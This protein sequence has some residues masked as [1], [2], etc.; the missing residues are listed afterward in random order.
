MTVVYQEIKYTAI[1]STEAY[2]GTDIEGDSR[3]V[4]GDFNPDLRFPVFVNIDGSNRL[5]TAIGAYAFRNNERI[6]AVHIHRYIKEIR[7]YGFDRCYNLH[8]V[9]FDVDSN[10]ESI[11]VS[12]FYGCSFSSII[13]PK[14]L[15]KFGQDVLGYNKNLKTIFYLGM[16]NPSSSL[17]IFFNGTNPATIYVGYDYPYDKFYN[18]VVTKIY[19]IPKKQSVMCN[20]KVGSLVNFLFVIYLS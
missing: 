6:K 10:L 19:G 15:K 1:N 5:I 2:V 14:T 8:K 11:N 18:I 13:L 3:A 9:T 16:I 12:S 4:A 7:H 17:N 20:K